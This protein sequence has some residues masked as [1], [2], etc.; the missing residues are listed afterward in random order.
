MDDDPDRGQ[1]RTSDGPDAPDGSPA[2]PWRDPTW[3]SLLLIWGLCVLGQVAYIHAFG[4]SLPW[5]DE[6][7]F[8][9]LA[10]GRASLSWDWLWDASNEN[11]LPVTRLLLYA[12][13]VAGGWD[14]QVMHYAGLAA[15]AGGALLLMAAA[16]SLRGRSA[17]SDAFVCLLVLSPYHYQ[18]LMMYGYAYAIPF[19]LFAAGIA[20]AAVGWHRRS[21]G[22]LVAFGALCLALTL[23]AGPGGNFWAAG[24]CGAG[25]LGVLDPR[26]S[27]AWRA[28]A[29]AGLGAVLALTVGLLATLP[30]VAHHEQFRGHGIGEA[31]AAAARISMAWL[32]RPALEF[33]WPWAIALL[34]VPAAIAAYRCAADGV[35][36]ARSR[37]ITPAVTDGWRLPVICLAS[38]LVVAAMGYGRA[39]YPWPWDSRYVNLTQPVALL[40]YLMMVRVRTAPA[41]PQLM[42]V[43]MA[44][45]VGWCWPDA[46][47]IGR[48]HH[49]DRASLE[50]DLRRGGVPL[51]LLS[52]RYIPGWEATGMLIGWLAD[53]READCSTFR[54]RR[55][56][57]DGRPLPRPLA[58][59][60]E[61][62]TLGDGATAIDDP[63]A[64]SSRAVESAA[65]PGRPAS[66]TFALDVPTGGSFDLWLRLKAADAAGISVAFDD[67]PPTDCPLP[68]APGYAAHAVRPAVV[69]DAGRH[70]LTITVHEPGP[71]IDFVELVPRPLAEQL[72]L[73]LGDNHGR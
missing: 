48:A 56:E 45:C 11:R 7:V 40:L 32:G 36:A 10:S 13:G 39:R 64:V 68:A 69:L 23:S 63:E 21:V 26:A 46:I 25:L 28:L 41:V 9:D 15:M 57:L 16:R 34:A 30:D 35:A 49:A 3:R 12:L 18:T 72:A 27:R 22:R 29:L 1:A 65:A 6:W 24:L 51:S 37:R 70:I 42:A 53:L 47:E 60:A 19:G 43:A 61:A 2:R 66:L 44:V 62:A 4:T 71:R 5:A 55:F 20:A 54:G 59:E 8:N 58:R 14:W 33:L 73:G 17:L 67:E 31:A 38:L 52:E 50:R